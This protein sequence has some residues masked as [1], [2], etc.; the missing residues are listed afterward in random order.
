MMA[1]TT[2]CVGLGV[3]LLAAAPAAGSSIRRRTPASATRDGHKEG[4]HHDNDRRGNCRGRRQP[5]AT[6][7]EAKKKPARQRRPFFSA[8]FGEDLLLI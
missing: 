6:A 7:T 8:S 3:E 2:D 1:R 5:L 4:R